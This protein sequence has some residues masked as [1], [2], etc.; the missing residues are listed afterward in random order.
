MH[1]LEVY[2]YYII[3]SAMHAMLEMSEH[4]QKFVLEAKAVFV[5]VS[6]ATAH[7]I[8]SS[9]ISPSIFLQMD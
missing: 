9:L 4:Q 3:L 8:R 1:T 2:N 5:K 6:L 7:T